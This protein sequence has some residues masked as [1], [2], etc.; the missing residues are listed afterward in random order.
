MWCTIDFKHLNCI[1]TSTQ[2]DSVAAFVVPF[3]IYG[4]W[5]G[6]VLKWPAIGVWELQIK[7]FTLPALLAGFVFLTRRF[8][9]YAI[10]LAIIY[11]PIMFLAHIIFA[12]MVG[13]GI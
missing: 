12:L 13:G 11:L 8:G 2:R 3:V 1:L 5:L 4:I 10:P 9:Y 6:A 7:S